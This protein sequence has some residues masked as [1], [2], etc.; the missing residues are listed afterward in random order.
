MPERAAALDRFRTIARWRREKVWPLAA[1]L[2]LSAKTTRQ[3][4][5]LIITWV[6]EGGVLCMALNPTNDPAN[7]DCIVPEGAVF[8]GRFAQHGNTLHLDPW[9]AVAW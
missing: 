7:L 4:N 3:G 6:F 2:C 1:T 9:S 5:C 8:A